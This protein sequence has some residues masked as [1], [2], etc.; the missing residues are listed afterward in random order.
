[1]DLSVS[2]E[3]E[4]PSA[5]GP[6]QTARKPSVRAPLRRPAQSDSAPH[7][8]A[9]QCREARCHRAAPR[10]SHIAARPPRPCRKACDHHRWRLAGGCPHHLPRLGEPSAMVAARNCPDASGM[11]DQPIHRCRHGSGGAGETHGHGVL[12]DPHTRDRRRNGAA[13]TCDS[14]C[15]AA[16]Q[17]PRPSHSFQARGVVTRGGGV[18]W[19]GETK[20]RPRRWWLTARAKTDGGQT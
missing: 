2:R 5:V 18:G 17:Q 10:V 16:H 8:R 11:Q 15:H 14:F 20:K 13:M 9:A 1:M 4:T 19:A 6:A 12:A 3:D 7:G